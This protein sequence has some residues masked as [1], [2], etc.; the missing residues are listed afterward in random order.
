MTYT[1][2]ETANTLR[3]T[4]AGSQA[5]TIL[6]ASEVLFEAGGRLFLDEPARQAIRSGAE[7]GAR[8][9]LGDIVPRIVVDVG[10]E[11]V[12]AAATLAQETAGQVVKTTTRE[13]A[14]AAARVAAGQV[15]RG[16]GRAAAL[17]GAMDAVI[18]GAEATIRYR[19]G[20]LDRRSAARHVA[21]ETATG[22]LASGAGVAAVAGV[23]ALTG[24]IG[25]LSAAAVAG[26]TAIAAKLALS[27]SSAP[28]L[29]TATDGDAVIDME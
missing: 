14:R 11:A 15:L 9:A 19:R 5:T 24:P 2:D 4:I 29:P 8:R 7:V 20:D 16:V 27:R 22:A 6:P 10:A 28:R 3:A 18:G 21:R 13:T 23:V 25:A 12:P 17:G 26:G 1:T